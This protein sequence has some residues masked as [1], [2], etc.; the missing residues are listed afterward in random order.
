MNELLHLLNKRKQVNSNAKPSK[1][2]FDPTLECER[3]LLVLFSVAASLLAV[4]GHRVVGGRRLVRLLVLDLVRLVGCSGGGVS[5]GRG[6]RSGG[7]VGCGGCRSGGGCGRC[8]G[9]GGRWP[10]VCG[11]WP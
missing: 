1:M 7:R 11:W 8:S 2:G 9:V 10:V 6:R 4:R 3:L 5:G